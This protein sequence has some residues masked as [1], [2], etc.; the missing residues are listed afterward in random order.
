MPPGLGSPTAT[1]KPTSV[2][3][4]ASASSGEGFTTPVTSP[5]REEPNEDADCDDKEELEE[6]VSPVAQTQKV[7]VPTAFAAVDVEGPSTGST[8]AAW[9]SRA[10]SAILAGLGGTSVPIETFQVTLRR[11]PDVPLG[12][13]I[14][15]DAEGVCLVVS[16]IRSGGAV[17]AWNHQTEGQL[18][19]IR[20]GDRIA[21][22]NAAQG[23]SRM[24]HECLEKSL[25]K[26][27][28]VRGA[29]QSPSSA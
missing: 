29:S 18:R 14:H 6:H 17:Q 16:A 21:Q 8:P 27:A 11:A 22:V 9:T 28:V 12:L 2:S 20:P 25:L 10:T 23:A 3:S 1:C 5:I 15:P 19:E 13:D 24:R 7:A 26:I 4:P